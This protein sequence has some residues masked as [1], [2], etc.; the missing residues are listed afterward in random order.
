MLYQIIS[1]YYIYQYV[2][3]IIH[4]ETTIDETWKV[5]SSR[6]V[7]HVCVCFYHEGVSVVERE[8]E[9]ERERTDGNR[10]VVRRQT[11]EIYQERLTFQYTKVAGK[12]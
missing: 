3:S 6:F 12:T 4:Y 9:R 8:R 10:E 5:V 1:L 11:T 7:H 2:S